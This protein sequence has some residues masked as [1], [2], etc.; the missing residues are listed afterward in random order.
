MDL[1]MCHTLSG[2][3]RANVLP[4]GCFLVNNRHYVTEDAALEAV[5]GGHYPCFVERLYRDM[6]ADV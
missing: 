6:L 4:S 1:G 3:A 5:F 2:H